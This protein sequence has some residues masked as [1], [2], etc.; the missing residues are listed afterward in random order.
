MTPNYV[1]IIKRLKWKD[2]IP[3]CPSCGGDRH[4]IT[5]GGTRFKCSTISC[6]RLHTL[7]AGT[8]FESSKIPLCKWFHAIKLYRAGGTIHGVADQVG[9]GRKGSWII[10]KKIMV[11]L[12]TGSIRKEYICKN[13]TNRRVSSI[14][15]DAMRNLKRQ[16]F[17]PDT[18]HENPELLE[19][20]ILQLK[21]KR[22]EKCN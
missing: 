12:E 15:N 10:R 19:I 1:A 13:A 20:K 3:I 18:I 6:Q 2:G 21:I 8:I 4:T 17:S 7:Q 22:D 14:R 11:F 16:G 5:V 9:I